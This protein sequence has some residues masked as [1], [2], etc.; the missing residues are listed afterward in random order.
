MLVVSN[1]SK[2]IY[3]RFSTMQR[4]FSNRADESV[5]AALYHQVGTHEHEHELPSKLRY[6]LAD[7]DVGTGA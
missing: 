4:I 5:E 6:K 2:K 1:P 7:H 3:L